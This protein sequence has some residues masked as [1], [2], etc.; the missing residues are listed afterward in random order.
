MF[1]FSHC[2]VVNQADKGS[3]IV[4][5]PQFNV[6]AFK[7]TVGQYMTILIL[8]WLCKQ[9]AKGILQIAAS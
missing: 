3:F 4:L 8:M 2:E 6:N 9:W 5:I 1:L 7:P